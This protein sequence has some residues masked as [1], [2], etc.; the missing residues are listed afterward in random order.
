MG[1]KISEDEAREIWEGIA[2]AEQAGF[3]DGMFSGQCRASEPLSSR[4]TLLHSIK[5]GM[6][7]YKSF[8]LKIYGYECTTP[9]FARRALERLRLI[10]GC[11]KGD[12]YYQ[13]I[14]AEYEHLR[15]EEQKK[16]VIRL[17]QEYEKKEGEEIRKQKIMQDLRQKSDRELL[18]LLQ[19]LR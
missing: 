6:K 1:W 15:N 8:F 13:T 7:L 3:F 12:A 2:Q 16:I 18:S 4:E 9:G 5:P 14:V 10:A 19:K 11:T 17:P